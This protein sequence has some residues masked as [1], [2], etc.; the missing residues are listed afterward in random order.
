MCICCCCLCFKKAKQ[1]KA[2]QESENTPEEKLECEVNETDVV[3]KQPK[4][5]YCSDGDGENIGNI[6]TDPGAVEI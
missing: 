5:S 2:H 6:G 4:T 1:R 3:T